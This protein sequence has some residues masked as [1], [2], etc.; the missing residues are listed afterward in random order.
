MPASKFLFFGGST[1]QSSGRE[2]AR[3]SDLN[4]DAA[5][6]REVSKK[7]VFVAT[8]STRAA[9]GVLSRRSARSTVTVPSVEE[10]TKKKGWGCEQ[11][12]L[13]ITFR[14]SHAL[15]C[16]LA[17]RWRFDPEAAVWRLEKSLSKAMSLASYQ[18]CSSLTLSSPSARRSLAA[19]PFSYLVFDRYKSEMPGMSF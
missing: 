4:V 10:D 19:Q 5:L 13:E 1:C 17:S 15:D 16:R 14:Q 12:W 6:G 2:G 11:T 7:K 9:K 8:L 3:K 18:A